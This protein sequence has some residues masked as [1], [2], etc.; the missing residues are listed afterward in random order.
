MR[1]F[2]S[3]FI[4]CWTWSS[5]CAQIDFSPARGER[6]LNGIKFPQ[7][8]FH[9]NGQAITYE[10]PRGWTCSGGGNSI[11]FAPPDIAQASG[12]ISQSPLTQPQ[13]FDEDATKAVVEAMAAA[14]PP[15]STNVTVVNVEKN[16]LFMSGRPTIE[17]VVAYD[18]AGQSFVTS[19]VVMNA[20]DTQV[21]FRVIAPKPVFNRVC[22][23]FRD[24]LYSWEL[25][26]PPPTSGPN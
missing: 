24:S 7:L 22:K 1:N 3:L 23:A 6:E 4:A 9:H 13:T 17:V 10:Q 18:V 16:P 12:E 19:T 14:V 5:A 26:A 25:S 21:R 2:L 20:E 15:N 11:R 8:I